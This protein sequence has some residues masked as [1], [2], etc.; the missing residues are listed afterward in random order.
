MAAS[1][2]IAGNQLFILGESGGTSVIRTGRDFELLRSNPVEGLF[3][4]TPSIAGE[5]LLLRS[6]DFV[7]CIRAR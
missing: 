2:W 6:S 5:Q 4:S 1:P 7:Y 3:W